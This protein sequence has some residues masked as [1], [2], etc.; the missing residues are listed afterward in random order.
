MNH[1]M[2]LSG[3]GRGYSGIPIS[4]IHFTAFLLILII[5]IIFV[6][7]VLFDKLFKVVKY[8]LNYGKVWYIGQITLH[9]Y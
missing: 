9:F 8:G 4:V 2:R 7:C 3:N 1:G 5:Y 6:I